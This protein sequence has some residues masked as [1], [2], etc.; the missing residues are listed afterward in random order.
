MLSDSFACGRE[1]VLDEASQE[2]R[3]E[4]ELLPPDANHP[5]TEGT[6]QAVA[7]VVAPLAGRRAT[8][9]ARVRK[10]TVEL[11][12]EAFLWEEHVGV[13]HD[14]ARVP[15]LLVA[16]PAGEAAPIEELVQLHLCCADGTSTQ[17]GGHRAQPW[18]AVQVVS[19]GDLGLD[20]VSRDPVSGGEPGEQTP[21][22]DVVEATEAVGERC[23]P[24]R[25][26]DRAAPLDLG[27]SD[28]PVVGGEP[29]KGSPT[30]R[31]EDVRQPVVMLGP[32]QPVEDGGGALAHDGVGPGQARGHCALLDRRT[33]AA[34][35]V[36]ES[37]D[38]GDEAGASHPRQ[39]DARDSGGSG[40]GGR[41]DS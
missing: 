15:D 8:S 40:H 4:H 3:P 12:D 28:A 13:R 21:G 16:R 31:D 26:S 10:P 2:V 34:R 20:V 19:L 24:I 41:E 23:Q 22:V 25:Q 35:D 27:R 30:V 38:A 14:R 6:Q 7:L 33:S 11:Q 17:R 5:I 32:E 29:T 37:A 18:D 36:A 1:R 9:L 39:A